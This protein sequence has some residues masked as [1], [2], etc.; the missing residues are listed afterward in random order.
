LVSNQ[1][2]DL[3]SVS[4]ISKSFRYFQNIPETNRTF[5]TRIGNA[6]TKS[7]LSF[8]YQE[9]TM[10]VEHSVKADR[11]G[12]LITVIVGVVSLIEAIRLFPGRITF[13][14]GDHTLPSLLGVAMLLLGLL[15]I[16][17]RGGAFRVELPTGR[18]LRNMLITMGILFLYWLLIP[19]LGYVISTIL[20]LVGLFK[21]IGSYSLIKSVVYGLVSITPLYLL[22]IYWLRISFPDG[23]FGF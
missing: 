8:A 13:F 4:L 12:G 23:I 20:A 9:V 19:I 5:Y 6:Y 15:L 2:F 16:V 17:K 10:L 3:K 18:L 22:F 7:I 21:V 1:F 11:I 14:V